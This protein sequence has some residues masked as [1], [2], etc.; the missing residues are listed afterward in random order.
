MM[1][2][3]LLFLIKNVALCSFFV[4]IFPNITFANDLSDVK[5]LID[6]GDYNKALE[7]SIPLA[8]NGNL[9]A[10]EILVELLWRDL[11]FGKDI[12]IDQNNLGLLESLGSLTDFID[13][14][15]KLIR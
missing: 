13:E 14:F 15:D 10:Q 12:T 8:Q 11:V 5:K 6:E 9:D 4:F 1:K 7:L 2:S 3:N